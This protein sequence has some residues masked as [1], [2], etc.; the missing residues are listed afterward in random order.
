MMRIFPAATQRAR[1][2]IRSGI[3]GVLATTALLGT[4]ACSG[5]DKST[6]P[7]DPANPVGT[8]ALFQVGQKN[9]PKVIFQGPYTFP[10]GGSYDE[11]VFTITGGEMILEENGDLH[12]AIDYKAV[13]D[14]DE[15]TGSR[16]AD[17]TY[18]IDGDQIHISAGDGGVDGTYRNGVI[19]LQL[20]L[21]GNG[22]L[23]T[24]TFRYV[25]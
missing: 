13:A 23:Q 25:P 22:D 16:K 4:V 11:F 18:E 12:V 5:S 2:T 1:R 15:A 21:V 17:G 20:D 8:F 19:T 24:Y 9:I 14:G 3:A 10:G 7:R 6:G